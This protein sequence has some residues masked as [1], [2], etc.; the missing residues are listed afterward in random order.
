MPEYDVLVV[1]LSIVLAFLRVCVS[2]SASIY[3]SY[4]FHKD[5]TTMEDLRE[6]IA[7]S[8]DLRTQT[9]GV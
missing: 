7:Q 2:N 4:L 3:C 5:N 9:R 1:Y 6:C 8:L